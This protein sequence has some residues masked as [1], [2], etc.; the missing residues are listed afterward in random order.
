MFVKML[1]PVTQNGSCLPV[2]LDLKRTLEV[3]RRL[4][5]DSFGGPEQ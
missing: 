5:V 4:S 2:T 3:K 1:S